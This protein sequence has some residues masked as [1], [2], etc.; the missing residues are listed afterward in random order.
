VREAR[1][2]RRDIPFMIGVERCGPRARPP[3]LIIE[4]AG[5]DFGEAHVENVARVA[6][7]LEGGDAC[8]LEDDALHVL[9]TIVGFHVE[10]PQLGQT[11]AF[12]GAA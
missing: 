8:F 11:L 2:P 7:M 1:C 6:P 9:G 12:G 3:K 10:D 4:G 5:L